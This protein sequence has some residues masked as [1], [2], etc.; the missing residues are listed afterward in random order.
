VIQVSIGTADVLAERVWRYLGPFKKMTYLE[1][2]NLSKKVLEKVEDVEVAYEVLARTLDPELTYQENLRLL[3]QELK[4]KLKPEIESEVERYYHEKKSWVKE[5]AEALSIAKEIED[6]VRKELEERAGKVEVAK[7]SMSK[8]EAFEYLAKL[9]A[10]E[11]A[12]KHREQFEEEWE[13]IAALPREEQE[14]ALR[15]LAR[16]IELKEER[17]KV[18]QP[19]KKKLPP[20]VTGWEAYV[21]ETKREFFRRWMQELGE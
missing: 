8:E 20:A 19:K 13:A 7:A 16:E 5:Q 3:E 17:E 6:R 11:R 9:V 4:T 12:E 21:P 14:R 15:L 18:L 10:R 1:V 2:L